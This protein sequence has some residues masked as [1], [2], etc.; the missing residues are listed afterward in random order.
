MKNATRRLRNWTVADSRELYNV[1]GWGAGY[2][3]I[4]AAGHVEVTPRGNGQRVDLYTL[5]C[6]LK[7][8]G[9][10]LPILVR[11]PE[12][13]DEQII[14]LNGAFA[15]AAAEYGY[16]GEYRAVFPVKVNQQRQVVEEIATFGRRFRIGLE[17]G[18]KAEL[19][20]ALARLEPEDGLI[21][22]NGYK[23]QA[24]VETALLASRLGFTIV[25]V[26]E[27][28]HE[29]DVVLKVA[30]RLDIEPV[31]G[32][33]AKLSARGRGKWAE[34]GG[35]RAKFGLRVA[36]IMATVERLRAAGRLQCL[37]LLHYHIGSQVTTI[38]AITDALVEASR[39]YVELCQ[40]GAPMAYF[41]VGGGL[42]VD[43]DGSKTSFASSANYN[44]REYAS[45]VIDVI[46][47]ACKDAGVAPPTIL[48]ES[49]RALVSYHSVLV[50]EVLDS[51][52]I[53]VTP[54]AAS[55]P[56]GVE[57]PRVLQDLRETLATATAKNYQ[58]AYHDAVYGLDEAVTLFNH[59]ILTLAERARAE[60][61]FWCCCQRILD[62][63]REEEYV[64]EELQSLERLM[65]DLYYCNVSFFQSLPD[66]WAIKQV[67]PILPLHR[68]D[69]EPT[70]RAVLA[71]MTCDSDGKLDHFV[72]L[73]EVKRVLEVHPLDDGPYVLGV[74]LVG[75]YQEI[76][77]DLHNLFG[78]THAVHVQ[79][80][81]GGYQ[82]GQVVEG[83]SA[84]DVLR[85]V[86]YSRERIMAALEEAGEKAVRRGAMDLGQ[87]KRLRQNLRAS[88]ESYTYLIADEA[89]A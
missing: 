78:D 25:L 8:R 18:S 48:S 31:L 64:P 69:C 34:S 60:Q 19:L 47:L 12:I 75:A 80:T 76:L 13:L 9:I 24:F 6:D 22:C 72:D 35:H 71:D 20:I 17:A 87:V 79:L 59:G 11:F 30:E 40:T 43:Y 37:R 84:A 4:N 74:F 58:E 1:E 57:E 65:A 82:I 15:S 3:G 45:C 16:G 85:Y 63:L 7:R 32:V 77:G 56:S 5:V 29:L 53:R 27:R 83:D 50:M 44:M 14:R 86:Q 68:L 41:D 38:R 67:F 89:E 39:I 62:L 51:E 33:R 49:G 88:L 46:G 52:Q 61:F 2:Y 66:T 26:L 23:D 28:M 10:E 55:E 21:V 36:D 73:R 81:E 70:R 54:P 42:A